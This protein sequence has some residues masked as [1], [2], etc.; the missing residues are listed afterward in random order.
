MAFH[1]DLEGHN[2]V[3]KALEFEAYQLNAETLEVNQKIYNINE[4]LQDSEDQVAELQRCAARFAG[5]IADHKQE[6]E[7][8]TP[9][10]EIT[11]E[12]IEVSG[13]IVSNETTNID[14]AISALLA[15]AWRR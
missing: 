3:S 10:K 12:K 15:L 5:S 11:R 8:L 7:H 1:S 4:A 6:L 2:A 13:A 14:S 9:Q